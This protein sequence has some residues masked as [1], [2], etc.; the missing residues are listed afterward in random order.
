MVR[1]T[2][3]SSIFL[4]F[5]GIFFI[6]TSAWG[7][8]SY[9]VTSSK[10]LEQ[11]CLFSSPLVPPRADSCLASGDRKKYYSERR[12]LTTEVVELS[13]PARDISTL[14]YDHVSEMLSITTRHGLPIYGDSAILR[15]RGQE[16]IQFRV[17]EANVEDL[18]RRF[19][20]S[21]VELRVGVLVAAHND[22]D[23]E[24][25]RLETIG[26]GERAGDEHSHKNQTRAPRRLL[27]EADVMYAQIVSESGDRVFA[28]YQSEF[29]KSYHVRTAALRVRN[30][31]KRVPRVEV[32]SLMLE[33]REKQEC[34]RKKEG[35]KSDEERQLLDADVSLDSVAR[36]LEMA[37]YPCYLRGLN[38]NDGM[39]GALVIRVSGDERG[40]IS[41][42]DILVDTLQNKD[43]N[44]CLNRQIRA[45]QSS[46]PLESDDQ[47]LKATLLFKLH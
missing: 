6:G 7:E 44:A 20:R 47:S 18:Q 3:V 8:T 19:S 27:L 40:Q 4:V 41:T 14:N 39:Q 45:I 13:I 46:I 10:D 23:Y 35:A 42:V 16:D 11:L 9:R 25:C 2:L 1:D 28:V 34:R 26:G 30:A 36:D 17:S 29:G 12:R 21:E 43:L 37:V 31:L 5:G 22:Y 24:F 33:D 32:A 38:K 15:L